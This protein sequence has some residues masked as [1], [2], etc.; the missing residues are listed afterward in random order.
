MRTL[1]LRAAIAAET[2]T[3]AKEPHK[4]NRDG[5]EDEDGKIHPVGSNW[6]SSGCQHNTCTDTGNGIMKEHCMT[7]SDLR[8]H[9][10]PSFK[11]L[12]PQDMTKPYPDCCPREWVCKPK[13]E[14]CEENLVPES[15][16]G[17]KE[18]CGDD[19]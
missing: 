3:D 16:Y 17:H 4:S 8:T 12:R 5:C 14:L 9:P 11:C 13:K 7:I 6:T 10:D 1:Y 18:W 2:E 19:V 15:H